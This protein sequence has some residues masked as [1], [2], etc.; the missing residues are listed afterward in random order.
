MGIY[1]R[2]Y[3]HANYGGPSGRGPQTRYVL[4]PITRAV[5]WLLIS[6]V[7]I[8]LFEA[9]SGQFEAGATNYFEEW[10]A[11]T[12]ESWVQIAQVWRLITC[13]WLHAGIWHILFNMLWLFFLGPRLEAYWGARKFM[14]YY[15]LC[16]TAGGIIY[17][18][19][20]LIHLLPPLPLVGA[21][22]GIMGVLAACAILFPADVVIFIIFPLPIRVVAIIFAAIS[23]VNAFTGSNVGGEIAHLT[24]MGAGAAYIWLSPRLGRRI[25]TRRRGA[26]DKKMQRQRELQLEVDR[27]LDK[28]HEQGLSSLSR[29]EKQLLQEAT[30]LE[31][32]RTRKIEVD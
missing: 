26:W 12:P 13:Q 18:L 1:D 3:T 30:K 20:T 21:S 14:F 23:V 16:G 22:G 17:V 25:V 10:G 15:L 19:A 24:G 5:K 9:I 28:V 31:Q 2:D 29:Q 8:F 27:I 6:N 7:A 11:L 4:P 32:E